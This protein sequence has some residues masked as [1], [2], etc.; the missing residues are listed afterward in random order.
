MSGG[1]NNTSSILRVA[2]T[3]AASGCAAAF[4]ELRARQ[5]STPEPAAASDAAAGA[6]APAEPSATVDGADAT[7]KPSNLAGRFATEAGGGGGGGGGAAAAAEAS[8]HTR[9]EGAAAFARR[10]KLGRSTAALPVS[11]P[12]PPPGLPTRAAALWVKC[13]GEGRVTVG[14][15]RSAAPAEF[16]GCRGSGAEVIP[17]LFAEHVT[18]SGRGDPRDASLTPKQVRTH[19]HAHATPR[20]ASRLRPEHVPAFSTVAPG[21]AP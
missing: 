18:Y 1:D 9:S 10:E 17:R 16:R 11:K 6:A 14:A 5:D 20:H 7:L 4:Q 19:R 12:T 21:P 3:S 8:G 15:L 2:P 13:G